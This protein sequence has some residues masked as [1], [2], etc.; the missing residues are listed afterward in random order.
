MKTGAVFFADF[1]KYS[2]LSISSDS[3][4]IDKKSFKAQGLWGKETKKYF[5]SHSNF[6][7]LSLI[8]GNLSKSKLLQEIITTTFF[9][10]IFSF[11][12]FKASV[13]SAPAGSTTIQ[14]SFK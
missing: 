13:D 10:L 6:K 4:K 14:S 1:F 8:S 3:H 9:H 12:S 11:K 7:L 5:L 2:N